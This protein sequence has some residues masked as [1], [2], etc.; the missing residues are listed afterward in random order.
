LEGGLF[1]AWR[2]IGNQS[3]LTHCRTPAFSPGWSVSGRLR[4]GLLDS[5]RPTSSWLALIRRH[6]VD[7]DDRHHLTPDLA[8]WLVSKPFGAFR[9]EGAK[10]P[11]E[12]MVRGFDLQVIGLHTRAQGEGHE[13]AT[14]LALFYAFNEIIAIDDQIA[15]YPGWHY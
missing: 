9:K 12:F 13:Q 11:L 2:G 6:A 15:N 5:R 4:W 1:D 3:E 14:S 10:Q 8:C 7:L